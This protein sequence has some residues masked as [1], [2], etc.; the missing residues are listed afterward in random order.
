MNR[1]ASDYIVPCGR[2]T[3][4]PPSSATRTSFPLWKAEKWEPEKLMALYKKAGARYFV[5][6]A[7]H[8]DNFDLWDSKYH[9]V[10]TRSGWDRSATWSA[11]GS[12]RRRNCGLPFGVSEHVGYS[13]SLVPDQSRLRQDRAEGRGA[14]RRC[15]PQVAGPLSSDRPPLRLTVASTAMIPDWHQEWFRRMKDLVDQHSSG[16]LLH[17]RRYSLRRRSAAAWWPTLQQ[18]PGRPRRPS[19]SRLHLQ[20][21]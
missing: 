9:S 20:E 14:L 18:Q 2:T 4:I 8:C 10:G 5:S 19:G 13:R 21:L 12:K 15:R 7:V 3:A 16:F 11:S 1:A 6:Q 17:R